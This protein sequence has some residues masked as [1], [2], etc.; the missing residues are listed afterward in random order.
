MS[1]VDATVIVLGSGSTP[2]EQ[3]GRASFEVVHA[4]E[5]GLGAALAEANGR[6]CIVLSGDLTV[7]PAFV[8]AHVQAHAGDEDLVG[9]GRVDPDARPSLRELGAGAANVSFVAR[10]GIEDVESLV[11]FCASRRLRDVPDAAATRPGGVT[12]G[13]DAATAHLALRR[14]RPELTA[15]LLGWFTDT[16]RREVLLRRVFLLLRIPSSVVA[17][18]GGRWSRFAAHL[19]YWR[20][21]KRFVGRDEWRRLA[22]GI[23]VLLYHAFGDD[24]NRFVVGLRTFERQMRLLSLLGW[25]AIDY[26][27]YA[28]TLAAGA[29][30]PPRTAVLTIDDG[31]RDNAEIAPI[32]ERHGFGATIFLVSGTLGAENDWSSNDPLRG[33]AMLSVDE[34]RALLARGVGVGFGAHTVTHAALPECPD[35][36]VVE[37]VVESKRQ[38]ELVLERPMRTFAYPYGGL[39]ERSV[40]AVRRAGFESACTTEPRLARPDDDPFLVP[41]IE[42]MH[43]DSLRRFLSYLW[44]GHS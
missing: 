21:V 1:G 41:R 20:T 30:P 8:H 4:T 40:A 23:P 26:E 42:V 38:L 6:I 3:D 22:R 28:T 25:R 10:P 12:F 9:V 29:L 5:R 2:G 19:E 44:F 43:G 36:A 31:Y 35:D 27:E 39:D 16:T 24:E 34:A 32:L 17:P 33:R 13:R 14:R 15:P 7:G 11:A 18:L 37:E